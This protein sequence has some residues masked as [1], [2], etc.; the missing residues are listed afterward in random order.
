[1]SRP[2]QVLPGRTY[3]ITRR[4]SERRFLLRPDDRT[5]QAFWY[6]LAEAAERCHIEICAVLATSNHY[7]AI[8]HDPEG[9]YP[10]FL[11]RF[12]QILAKV[13]NV[14]WGRWE[15]L[16]AN[17]Q[18][19]VVHLVEPSDAFDKMI[20]VLTNPVKDHLVELATVW[21]GATSLFAQLHDEPIETRRPHWFFAEDTTMPL[22]ATVRMKRLPGFEH[23]SQQEWADMITTAIAAVERTA[24]DERLAQRRNGT[25]S[26]SVIGC[27]TLR[28]QSAF[29]HPKSHEPRRERSP[30][31]AAK[32][33]W[34]RIEAL[35]RNKRF[36]ADYRAALLARRAGDTT[37]LFPCGSYLLPRHGLA[38]C[39]PAPRT[40]GGRTPGAPTPGARTPTAA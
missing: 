22:V 11:Q 9:R 21:P 31:V 1:V 3:L 8:C 32:N 23:L 16:W 6:C 33:K 12:H 13:Q 25:G 27:K 40:P 20:Y 24:R 4:C 19:S 28:T 2:R 5:N 29:D 38:R 36:L 14:H 26:G 39:A 18:T 34:R 17:E 10:E 35:Q 37:V 30:R 15:A 7:H